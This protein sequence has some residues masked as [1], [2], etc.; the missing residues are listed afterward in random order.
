MERSII[1]DLVQ[2]NDPIL[3]KCVVNWN[4]LSKTRS[5]SSS[6]EEPRRGRSINDVVPRR[7]SRAIKTA[8]KE[9]WPPKKG[10]IPTGYAASVDARR[11]LMSCAVY[12]EAP[13]TEPVLPKLPERPTGEGLA[14]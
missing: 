2:C 8:G 12:R 14:R 10:L 11:F 7:K 4:I 1:L 9:T 3:S 6:S 13:L 5:L